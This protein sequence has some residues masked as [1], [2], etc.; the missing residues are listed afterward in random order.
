MR[1]LDESDLRLAIEPERQERPTQ[2]AVHVQPVSPD[3]M[4]AANSSRTT[5][6]QPECRDPW[7]SPLSSMAVS[8]ENQIDGVVFLHLIQ[9]IR[10]MGQ[11]QGEPAVC[12]RRETA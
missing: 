11:Q 1:P 5:R 8:A 3:L 9:D 12:G 10:R 4:M 2:A 6:R 7:H